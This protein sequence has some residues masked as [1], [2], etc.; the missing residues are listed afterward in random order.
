[1]KNLWLIALALTSVLFFAACKKEDAKPQTK[2][3]IL[4]QKPWVIQKFE[5]RI[6]TAAWVDDFPNFD[7]CSKDDLYIFRA[8]NTYEFNEGPT[9]CNASDPQIFE[10]GNWIFK[11]NETVLS[12]DGEDFNIDQ[13][14]ENSMVIS[15]S[16]SFGGVTYNVRITFRNQ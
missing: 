10:T 16:E 7:A 15:L 2:T 8:N 12:L 5:E 11:N 1:M 9:K 13:L 14:A 3:E 4:T 6:G